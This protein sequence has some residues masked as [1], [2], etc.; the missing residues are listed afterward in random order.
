[1]AISGFHSLGEGSTFRFQTKTF[2][3]HST[4]LKPEPRHYLRFLNVRSPS[5]LRSIRARREKTWSCSS[6][7]EYLSSLRVQSIRIVPQHRLV[8]K[9]TWVLHRPE[10]PCMVTRV[11][12]FEGSVI[13]KSGY[14]TVSTPG[15]D[16]GCSQLRSSLLHFSERCGCAFLY[17]I[18]KS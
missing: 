17:C 1:M 4:L 9:F 14:W 7:L 8:M 13:I 3:I 6:S 16:D 11:Q 10:D 12:R 2:G 5:L 15:V 18:S